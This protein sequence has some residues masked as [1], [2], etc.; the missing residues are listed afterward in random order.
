V[1]PPFSA[2]HD[3]QIHLA[4]TELAK[5]KGNWDASVL[6]E[7]M[8]SKNPTP[9]PSE[10]AGRS[11]GMKFTLKNSALNVRCGKMALWLPPASEKHSSDSYYRT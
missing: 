4:A 11:I 1:G 2:A 3:H 7:F 9:V 8:S 6:F 5:H 10:K